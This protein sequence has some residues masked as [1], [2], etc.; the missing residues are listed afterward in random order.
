METAPFPPGHLPGRKA[1]V[2]TCFRKT[3]TGPF[4]DRNLLLAKG[5][6]LLGEAMS[7]AMQG[8]PRRTGHCEE[9]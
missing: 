6:E 7:H 3:L 5:L 8:H 4:M 1:V 2:N 9:F